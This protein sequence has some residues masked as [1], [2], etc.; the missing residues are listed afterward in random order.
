MEDNRMEEDSVVELEEACRLPPSDP[1]D[2][3]K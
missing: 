3:P 2:K 1:V